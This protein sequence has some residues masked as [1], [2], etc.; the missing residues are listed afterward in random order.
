MKLFSAIS[1]LLLAGLFGFLLGHTHPS[2][3][4]G[5]QSSKKVLYWVDPM[6]PAYKSDHPGIAPDCAMKLEPVYADS[7][8]AAI[9]TSPQPMAGPGDSTRRWDIRV[10]TARRGSETGSLRLPGRVVADETRVFNINAGVDGFVKETHGDAIGNFVRKD[11]PLATIYS[12]E[13]LTVL[14][15]YLSASE[16]S[17]NAP[18]KDGLAAALGTTG[19]LN[20]SDRLRN[21]GVS[22][23]QIAQLKQTRK[24]PED[25]YVVAPVD[26]FILSRSIAANARFERHT[27]FYRIADLSHVWI[28]ATVSPEDISYFR[29]GTMV[30]VLVPDLGMKFHARVSSALPEVDPATRLLQLRLETDNPRFAMRPEML[31]NVDLPVH[32]PAGLTLPKDAVMDS[33]R[34]KRVFV[35]LADGTFE[36]RQVET[37]W[38]VG[39]RVQIVHG[40]E[41]GERV[42]AAASFVLDSEASLGTTLHIANDPPPEKRRAASPSLGGTA[43]PRHAQIEHG[44]CAPDDAAGAIAVIGRRMPAQTSQSCE[45]KINLAKARQLAFGQRRGQP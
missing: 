7:I 34:G 44:S 11:Q 36:P 41:E 30:R 45:H 27:E 4:N 14:G 17:Q 10:V 43:L 9:A 5:L 24:I 22:D 26:G 1:A 6:H 21:L 16:R 23:T 2:R 3:S 12:P 38:R 15:G 40:L 28:K 29:P 32:A 19:I 39:D 31:V 8:I 13:F 25:I 33:G 35:Q 37:G 18:T 42:A 20:W